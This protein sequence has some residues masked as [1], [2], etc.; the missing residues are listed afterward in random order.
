MLKKFYPHAYVESVFSID[1]KKL[2]L[3]GY[4]GLIFDIDNTLVPHG[5]DSTAKVDVLF[6]DIHDIGFKTLLLSNNSEERI[7]RF[8][9]N[10]DTSY[11]AE[12]NKPHPENYILALDKMQLEKNEVLFIGDQIFT[13]IYGANQSGISSI[14]V[15][16]LHHADE[17]NFGKRRQLEKIILKLYK[18]NKKFYNW[19]GNVEKEEECLSALEKR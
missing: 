3:K 1:Y 11:I 17:T 14:L 16:F 15:H 8:V 2:Y 18:I 12:A 19:L 5:N 7:L 4:R 6:K 13:D 9:R 10:I